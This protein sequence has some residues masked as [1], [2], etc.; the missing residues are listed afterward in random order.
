MGMDSENDTSQQGQTQAGNGGTSVGPAEDL[1]IALKAADQKQKRM[2]RMGTTLFAIATAA[3]FL[4]FVLS[5]RDPARGGVAW[6]QSMLQKGGL[7]LIYILVTA[8]YIFGLQ[9]LSRIDYAAPVRTFLEQAEL[10][11]RF[12]KPSDWTL[13]IVGL[14]VVCVI[15]TMGS[16]P[17]LSRLF[18][19]GDNHVPMYIIFPL[20]ILLVAVLGFY[21]TKKDWERERA[22][23]WHQIKQM[24]EELGA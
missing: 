19:F 1:I 17:Y 24:Q 5:F 4:I 20:F 2:L 23:L 18:G 6:E 3:F 13:A 15:S 22:G 14:V 8:F 21:F 7:V 16:V 10:R 9:K 11:Y 12:M